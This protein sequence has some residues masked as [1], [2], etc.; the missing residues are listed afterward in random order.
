MPSTSTDRLSGLTTSVAIKA[1]VK[2]VSTAN[3]TLS[4]LQTV[5][6]VA[7]VAGDRVLVKDQS[8]AVENGIYVVSSSAWQRAGDFDGSRDAVTGTLVMTD[9]VSAATIFYRVTTVDPVIPGTSAL[10]FVQANELQNPYPRSTAE[11]AAGVVPTAFGEKYGYITRYGAVAGNVTDC[12]TALQSAISVA[13]ENLGPPVHIPEGSFK[14]TSPSTVAAGKAVSFEGAGKFLS[15]LYATGFAS[16]S[17]VISYAGTTGSRIDAI[18]CRGFAIWSDNNLAR[19]ITATW[20]INSAFEDLYFYQLKNGWVG[21]SSFG[22]KFIN[23]N[24]Y[25]VTEDCYRLGIDCNNST[26]LGTRCVGTNGI[27]VNSECSALTI[28]GCDFEGIL[29]NGAA[30]TIVPA[31][32]RHVH[33]VHIAGCYFENIDG[34]AIYI[35]GTDADSVLGVSIVG[36]YI[37]GG[38]SAYGNT[39]AVN[40]IQLTRVKGFQIE[41]NEFQDWQTRAFNGV[42]TATNGRIANNT[43]SRNAIPDL[44]DV[45]FDKSVEV[46]NNWTGGTSVYGANAEVGVTYSASITPDSSLGEVFDITATN[47][48]AFTMNAA[49]NGFAGKR[50]TIKIRNTAGGSLG[51]ITWGGAYKMAAWTSPANGFSRSITFV[52]DGTNWIEVSR[53][54]ADVPN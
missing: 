6:G 49:T 12:S 19:G 48:T 38:F 29:T 46:R 53:T 51:A 7:L 24:A 5:N 18:H 9:G 23:N 39:N 15:I 27:T 41:A 40:A 4:G 32:T 33:G 3:L 43:N 2:T 10:T 52:N 45:A 50:I 37:T 16:D 54:T 30:I 25:L 47:G 8:N 26:F 34:T 22:N 1:P 14:V 35:A 11:I 21:S 44:S 13:S 28:L 17:A 36:N 20:V 42:A 31:T